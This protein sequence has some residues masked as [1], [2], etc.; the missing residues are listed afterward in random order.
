LS[1]FDQYIQRAEEQMARARA[2]IEIA[3]EMCERAAAMRETPRLT[4]R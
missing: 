3:H 4:N 1:N 2:M